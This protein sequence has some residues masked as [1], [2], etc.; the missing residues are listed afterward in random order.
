M[1]ITLDDLAWWAR[2]L[3]GARAEGQLPPAQARQ[4][5]SAKAS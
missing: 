4:I 1:A 3:A 2:L 5:A